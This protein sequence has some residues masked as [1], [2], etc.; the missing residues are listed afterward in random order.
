MTTAETELRDALDRFCPPFDDA[1]ADWGDVLRRAGA[2][3]SRVWRTRALLVALVLLVVAPATGFGVRALQRSGP[4]GLELSARIGSVGTLTLHAPR[5]FVTRMG[6]R[7]VPHTFGRLRNGSLHRSVKPYL[8]WDLDAHPGAAAA[9]VLELGGRRAMVLC[10]PCRT[11]RGTVVA[12]NDD[13][14]ALVN[15]RA[16]ARVTTP[17]G[18]R[19]G[20]VRL[21]RR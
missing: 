1:V 4:S 2:N 8:T 3:R 20:Q 10:R 16:T 19:R 18:D 9:V 12:S 21:H 15:D 5:T 13:L 6:A 7:R 17:S 14:V 11:L